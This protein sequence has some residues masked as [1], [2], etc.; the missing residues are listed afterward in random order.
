M[1]YVLSKNMKKVK[2]IATENCHF[3]SR[4]KLL[5]VACTCFRNVGF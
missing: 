2:K 4:D 3:Y 1:T 5:Y